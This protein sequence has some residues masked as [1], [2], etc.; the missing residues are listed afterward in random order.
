MTVLISRTADAYVT[1]R[2]LHSDAEDNTLFDANH[3]DLENCIVAAG[4]VV[5]AVP[6]LEHLGLFDFEEYDEVFPCR[7]AGKEEAVPDYHAKSIF[8]FERVCF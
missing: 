3:D 7:L 6:C 2:L 4:K 1:G 8:V 5:A